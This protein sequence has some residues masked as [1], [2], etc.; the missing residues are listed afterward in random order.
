MSIL[1][2]DLLE[3]R[4]L[5]VQHWV[6]ISAGAV[7]T[8]SLARIFYNRKTGKYP[9]GPPA[10][11]VIG[12]ILDI[13]AE[14]PW[15]V[16]RKWGQEANSDVI[17][18]KIPGPPLVVLNSA[19]AADTLLIK[20]SGIYSDRPRLVMLNEL[21]RADW[22][23]A[24]MPYGERFK[25]ARKLFNKHVDV[26]YCRP[27][28][29]SAV[30]NFLKDA[31]R[32]NGAD[33]QSLIRLMTG[34]FILGAGY[35]IEAS[36]AEDKYIEI[37]ETF[38]REIS[39]ATQRG[40][41]AVDA[42]PILK[43]IPTWFPGAG[44][45]HIAARIGKYAVEARTLPFAYTEDQVAKGTA[46]RSFATRFLESA[47]DEVTPQ[48]VDDVRSIIGNMYIA[49]ADTTVLAMRTFVLAMSL[50]PEAQKKG[51]KA[52]DAALGERFPD[53]NDYGRIPY[54]DAIINEVLRWKP[55]LPL[56]IPHGPTEDDH[57]DGYFIP[58]GSIVVANICA[59]LQDE[60]VY[61]P[62]TD[63]FIPE[64]FLTED[65]K[66]STKL[67]SEAAFGY[68]RRQCTGKSTDIALNLSD[69]DILS[70]SYG[71]GNDLDG[72]CVYSEHF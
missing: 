14:Y 15:K 59:I 3:A 64:R 10:W 8:I 24:L 7:F 39:G 65:G 2:M 26:P 44:F 40:A 51:Q 67:N 72:R 5:F 33:H 9:P 43:H 38:I 20:R 45:H 29:I 48:H 18:L 12:N 57:Y 1:S 49:G 27:Q 69:A 63:K 61:G 56:S 21:V 53:F 54:I 70:R 50:Y 62:N 47:G 41:F 42:F 17:S 30:R 55:P 28:A 71:K 11:P 23:L 31:L 37:S 6:A 36:S 52:I 68:G 25:A 13:P 34:R 22:N 19:K 4:S 46:R 60:N 16:Y 32:T 66:L 35:G 58:K